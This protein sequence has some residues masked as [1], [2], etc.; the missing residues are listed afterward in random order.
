MLTGG[1]SNPRAPPLPLHSLWCHCHR[2]NNLHAD[3]LALHRFTHSLAL[4]RLSRRHRPALLYFP[5]ESPP[6]ADRLR[7]CIRGARRAE[8][9]ARMRQRR[10][11]PP[12]R[13]PRR[14]APRRRHRGRT[15]GRATSTPADCI[16]LCA[17]FRLGRGGHSLRWRPRRRRLRLPHGLRRRFPG[18]RRARPG[19]VASWH[20][21]RPRLCLRNR[22]VQGP[23]PRRPGHRNHHSLTNR[24][25]PPKNSK[26]TGLS[27][28]APQK[29]SKEFQSLVENCPPR[30]AKTPAT[31][32]RFTS[33]ETSTQPLTPRNPD[34]FSSL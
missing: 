14:C 27:T 4:L 20:Q 31:N 30:R 13:R 33:A 16:P 26:I 24:F 18:V 2:S 9:Q 23:G 11:V 10:V 12:R 21:H 5:G 32:L 3:G 22:D 25:L 6:G 28:R 7:G 34:S 15:L 8:R 19:L 29:P 17:L 1:W